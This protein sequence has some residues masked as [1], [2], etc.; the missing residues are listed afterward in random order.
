MKTLPID[1]SWGSYMTSVIQQ[2]SAQIIIALLILFIPYSYVMF[3][4]LAQVPTLEARINEQGKDLTEMKIS[5]SKNASANSGLKDQLSEI[6]D[7]IKTVNNKLDRLIESR[8]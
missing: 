6:K 5:I 8:K 2:Y 4:K 7:D 1:N 3:T